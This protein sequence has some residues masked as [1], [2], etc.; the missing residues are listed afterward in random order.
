ML[1]LVS[2]ATERGDTPGETTMTTN[3]PIE[4]CAVDVWTGNCAQLDAFRLAAMQHPIETRAD[5]LIDDPEFYAGEIIDAERNALTDDGHV[6]IDFNANAIAHY[7]ALLI[8]AC[9]K[10]NKRA[11][12][13][14]E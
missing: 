10:H 13:E 12:E 11:N 7:R 8:N 3:N 4:I 6:K 9:E 5:E 14:L 2:S 1:S